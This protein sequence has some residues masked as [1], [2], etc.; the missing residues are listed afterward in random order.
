MS[1]RM[2][3]N[4]W[5]NV[6]QIESQKICDCE[7]QSQIECQ[8]NLWEK[9]S[10][11]MSEN[12]WEKMSGGMADGMSENMWEKMSGGMS[13]GMSENTWENMSDRMSKNNWREN[14]R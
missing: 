8:E 4:M 3:E 11:R 13:D 6:R 14:V 12:M 5:E 9:M 2:S 1:N 7:R 10:G